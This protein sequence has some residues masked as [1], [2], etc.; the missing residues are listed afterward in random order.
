MRVTID[1][2][3]IDP[4]T[5]Q[6]AIERIAEAVGSREPRSLHVVTPNAQFVQIARSNQRFADIVNKS[7]LSVADGVPLVWASRLLGQPLPGRVNGTDLMVRLCQE[8]AARGWSVYFLGGKPEAGAAA[9]RVMEEAYPGLKVAGIDCPPMGFSDDPKLDKVAS[10]RVDAASPDVVFVGLGAPKQELWID[11]HRSLSAAVMV[12]VG[13]SFELVA[14]M[15][16]RAPVFFQKYG[17]EW[18]WRVGM[19]PGRLWK[20]YLIGNTLFVFLV[21]RQWLTTSLAASSKPV[22]TSEMGKETK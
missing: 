16:K 9:A 8:S 11:G 6:Q 1:K 22:V 15:T 17:M 2:I 18:L 21:L 20:R 19:E 4:V 13:G 14:G 12:G 10:N 5:M 3:E 7:D